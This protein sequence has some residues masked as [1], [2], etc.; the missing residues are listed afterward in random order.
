MLCS[1]GGARDRRYVI[2]DN[3]IP[4]VSAALREM[5]EGTVYELKMEPEM[6]FGVAGSA[7]LGVPPNTALCVSPFCSFGAVAA[8]CGAANGLGLLNP[9]ALFLGRH[10]TLE[11]VQ[12]LPVTDVTEDGGVV[13][14]M[15][16]K[17]T[18]IPD[19]AAAFTQ[20]PVIVSALPFIPHPPPPCAH[21]DP[22]YLPNQVG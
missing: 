10:A 7:K 19:L 20:Q 3:T 1:A 4:G 8:C 22:H 13:M 21:A 15:L 18:R 16:V 6:G 9:G 12:I 17:E 5:A 2:K 11:L 14:K